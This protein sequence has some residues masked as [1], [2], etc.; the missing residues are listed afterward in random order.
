[1]QD[2]CELRHGLVQWACSFFKFFCV[3]FVGVVFVCS[4][5][6]SFASFRLHRT[7]LLSMPALDTPALFSVLLLLHLQGAMY[8]SGM[9]VKKAYD[10]ALHHFTLAAHQARLPAN[11]KAASRTISPGACAFFCAHARRTRTRSCVPRPRPPQR[12]IRASSKTR[13]A[14]LMNAAHIA[15]SKSARTHSVKKPT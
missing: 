8:I 3:M 10:K 6:P 14:K 5:L 9:G 7:L 1:M 4:K 12:S 2:Q 15:E 13:L 11:T